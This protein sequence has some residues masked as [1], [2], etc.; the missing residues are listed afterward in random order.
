[1]TVRTVP[2]PKARERAADLVT[3]KN[4]GDDDRRVPPSE[5]LVG[6]GEGCGAPWQPSDNPRRL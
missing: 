4:P 5:H 2:A 6:Q 1:M 3:G